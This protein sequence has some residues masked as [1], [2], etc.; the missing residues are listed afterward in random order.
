M[1]AVRIHSY[2]HADQMKLEETPRPAIRS[3]EALVR[4]R[5]AGVNPVDW[6]IREGYLKNIFRVSFPLTLGQDFAGDIVEAGRDLRDFK[7]GD[8]LFGFASGSY[9]E[10]TTLSA[11]DLV[12][13]PATTDYMT[14]ASIPTAGLT[15]YQVILDV[16]KAV[17][18]LRILIHGAAGGVGSFAVQLAR[19]K[20]ARIFA[21]ASGQDI[22]YLKSLGA[23]QVVDYRA[24]RFEQKV[25]EMDAVVDLIGGETLV[26]S[27]QV[28]KPRGLIVSTVAAPNQT[29]L[30]KRQLRGQGFQMKRD[31]SQLAHLAALVDQGILKAKVSQVMPLSEAPQAHE[32][33]ENG[34]SRGKI[35]L[36]VA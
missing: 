18:D 4:I 32:L 6:K 30:E 3:D 13:M 9:A 12:R 29:D 35:V 8:R 20:Q 2:G 10:Y 36:Q 17:K 14:A 27:Y 1:K 5:A 22:A 34:K 16:V 24:E 31:P 11:K 25:Q 21:T 23:E 28:L 19:W 26:R 15:A 7:V 33:N